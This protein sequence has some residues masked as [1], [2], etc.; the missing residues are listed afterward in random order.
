MIHRPETQK[1]KIEFPTPVLE[2]PYYGISDKPF[3]PEICNILMEPIDP[4]D[5]EIKPDG[6][7]YLPE[8]KYRRVLNRAFGPGGWCLLP[9]GPH[10][11]NHDRTN[12]S[13]EYALYVDGRFISQAWGEQDY[14]LSSRS[15]ATALEGAKSNALMRC[16]KDLGIASELWDPNFILEWKEKYAISVWCENQKTKE[17]KRLWRR[18][19]RKAFDYP[20]KEQ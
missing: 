2:D 9:R 14:Y 16:C 3:S 5:V 18:K 13:A 12:V 11:F 20:W 1:H 8:I 6:I 10:I 15:I 17:R 4:N 19:D 7:I